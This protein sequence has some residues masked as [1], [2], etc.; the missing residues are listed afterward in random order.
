M[1]QSG[2]RISALR[3]R[4][5][6]IRFNSNSLFLASFAGMS[7]EDWENLEIPYQ[8]AYEPKLVLEALI[9][10]VSR[11]RGEYICLGTDNL[12]FEERALSAV[13]ELLRNSA[14]ADGVAL[15]VQFQG[16]DR[17]DA[18]AA[19]LADA[20]GFEAQLRQHGHELSPLTVLPLVV[21][22][23][24]SLRK[25]LEQLRGEKFESLTTF[26]RR[27]ITLFSSAQLASHQDAQLI[28]TPPLTKRTLVD[29]GLD[30]LGRNKLSEALECFNEA[31]SIPVGDEPELEYFR[32]VTFAKL[33][34]FVEAKLCAEK[35]E[36]INLAD[37]RVK[38]L[39]ELL[40]PETPDYRTLEYRHVA[41]AVD[42]VFGY[43]ATG[44]EEKLFSIVKSL[45][46]DATILEI[47][48]YLGR[49]TTAMSFACLGTKRRIFVN[50]T[51]AGNDG[52]MGRSEDFLDVFTNHL[53]Q[54]HL[55][56]FVT[57][58]QGYSHVVLKDWDPS[59]KF[60]FVF[61]DG[62]HEYVDV[63]KDFEL[64][65]PHVK[66]GGWIAF[67]DVEPGWVGSWRVWREVAMPVLT[68]HS[69]V[70]TL[71]CGRKDKSRE[72]K[73]VDP[74]FSYGK[75]WMKYM[76][77]NNPELQVLVA[78]LDISMSPETFPKEAATKAIE[79]I[80]LMPE[81]KKRELR[82]MLSREARE[83]GYFR[84]WN[85]IM[86]EKEGKLEEAQQELALAIQYDKKAVP[87]TRII[88]LEK[89]SVPASQPM[90]VE[91]RAL[92]AAAS[93]AVPSNC[94]AAQSNFAAAQSRLM[95][96]K[97]VLPVVEVKDRIKLLQIHS[98]YENYLEE[99]YRKD[100]GL[101]SRTFA[102]Q[103]DSLM[104]DGFS[105]SHMFAPYLRDLGYDSTLV[106]GNCLY[107][108][109][110]WCLERRVTLDTPH[111]WLSEI[112]RKQVDTLK[113]DVLYL[114][115]PVE[116]DSNFVRGCEWK[117][118]LVMGW[119]AAPTPE[120]TDWSTFDLMLSHLGTSR[121]LA[122]RK[123]VKATEHF[124][125]GFPVFM[126]EKLRNEQKIWDVVFSGQWT[127][128]HK[129][130][131]EFLASVAQRA[132]S[133]G[134]GGKSPYSIAYFIPSGAHANLPPE[135]AEI[136]RG[137]RWATEM[138]RVIKQAR[139]V[140]NAEINL[141]QGEA[142]N[143][144]LFEVTGTGSFLLTQHHDNI[145]QYFKPGVEIETFKTNAELH[146]KIDYYLA[147]P[148]ER[149]AIARR[150]QERCLRDY[151]MNERVKEFNRIVRRY[152]PASQ[153][154]TKPLKATA[155]LMSLDLLR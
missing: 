125:P 72:L 91:S 131:N 87:Q 13:Q 121:E 136:N 73:L 120:T 84:Y 147:H 80:G 126:A 149:E 90:G 135:V 5:N 23:R 60:D 105:G 61:I 20:A 139:I 122:K 52:I 98:F 17:R 15:A 18:I 123:G 76:R 99:H 45:P 117:P 12:Q 96:E 36:K 29:R 33:G 55:D 128:D 46:E 112:T 10:V 32:A 102:Q 58:K 127:N 21:W 97:E 77:E 30:L 119:R 151:N 86:L 116:F 89:K 69:Y 39:L 64:I 67:H 148:E 49:S 154:E 138:H 100:A 54:Y 109:V 6:K 4:Q 26:A 142:G 9:G 40:A 7:Q 59:I 3:L 2:P 22:R 150:G 19:P 107:S 56:G 48:S 134:A 115:H 63:L 145:A 141:A 38:G 124:A 68:E 101:A 108:Q 31:R 143:M 111:N 41:K 70:S 11:G 25:L 78:A 65:Y 43:M 53:A 146:E 140:L 129:V 113:P 51:F 85:S 37:Q 16:K 28:V 82:I 130:R 50:D 94:A 81:V 44:Q 110:Q 153:P 137:A 47:G 104:Q 114:S 95:P 14:A 88:E 35:A 106:I 34:R 74:N 92:A 152:L 75:E 71:A 118:K 132:R 1:N 133:T 66:E 155:P 79:I 27:L 24:T 42:S 83:D 57:P 62:S 103:I 144:R 93:A 8:S